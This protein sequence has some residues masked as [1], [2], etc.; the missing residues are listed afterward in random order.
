MSVITASIDLTKIPK[1]KIVVGQK[2]KY[3]NI[4]IGE[5]KDGADQYGNTHWIK[6]QKPKDSQED[7]IYL[8]NGKTWGQNT[9]SANNAQAPQTQDED[10]PF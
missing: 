2:G 1:D 8:G 3:L 9:S 7:D 5:R 6:V 4:V 10:L